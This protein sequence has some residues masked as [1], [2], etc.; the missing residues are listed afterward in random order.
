MQVTNVRIEQAFVIPDVTVLMP[1]FDHLRWYRST[2]G[3]TGLFAPATGPVAT[4]AQLKGVAVTRALAGTTFRI[5]A[6]GAAEL[7]LELGPDPVELVSVAAALSAL[8]AGFVTAVASGP[9]LTI[10][11]SLTG[12]FATLEVL[13]CSAAGLLGFVPGEVAVGLDADSALVPGEGMYRLIDF[14]SSPA[15]Y[16]RTAA[17]KGSVQAPMSAPFPSRPVEAVPLDNLVG[18]FVRLCDLQGRPLGGRRVYI[19]N[20]FMP[21]KTEDALSGRAWGVFRQFEEIV[22]DSNGYASLF[23]LRGAVVDVTIS[24]TGFTR[25]LVI[26]EA[27]SITQCDLLDATL[28]TRDE[29]GVQHPSIDFAIRT[30]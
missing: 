2:T 26:P 9:E 19:H 25:R 4:A 17:V 15:F 8:G 22:T 6:A 7:S 27:L 21:N 13:E 1:A 11:T 3:P 18:C 20:V 23:L 28:S 14:Q 29:F 30:T 5:R 16:Y 10:T 12:S 24:G